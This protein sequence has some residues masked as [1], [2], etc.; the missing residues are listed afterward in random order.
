MKTEAQLE[1]AT[2]EHA[3]ELAETMRPEDAAEAL[4][5]TG[6]GP[7][8]SVLHCLESSSAAWTVLVG[9]EVLC[10][11]GVAPSRTPGRGI[12]WMLS[13]EQILRHRRPFIRVSRRVVSMMLE[14]Y[15]VLVNAVDARYWLSIRWLQW[16]GFTVD[17]TTTI[18]VRG[19]CFHPIEARR[20]AWVQ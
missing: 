6:E 16:M 15:P 3:Y 12:A 4:A 13:S 9:G 17:K 10:L 7:L 1:Q 8:Q 20:D 18:E 5:W 14:L 19:Q 11:C 2:V